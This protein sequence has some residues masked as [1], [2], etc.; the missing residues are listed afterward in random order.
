[1]LKLLFLIIDEKY[2]NKVIKLF[3]RLKLQYNLDTNCYG[4]A[5]ESI[6]KYFGLTEVKRKLFLSIILDTNEQYIINSLNEKLQLKKIGIGFLFTISLTSG[7][8]FLID[9]LKRTEGEI[10]N[11]NEYELIISVTQ[12]GYSTDVMDAAKKYGA[13]GG[14]IIHGKGLNSKNSIKFL[15]YSI[16]PE[17]DIVLIVVKKDNKKVI[18]QA[19]TDKVGIKTEGKGICF[20]LPVDNVMG[21]GD[22]DE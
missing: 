13:H 9:T 20:S 14:T 11:T 15:G 1:M 12:E 19:I 22:F 17:K 21:I 3:D 2:E 18:M 8:K 7:N 10:M 4:T 16:E 6:L 5:S